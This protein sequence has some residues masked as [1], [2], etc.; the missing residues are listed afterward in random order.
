M[1][2]FVVGSTLC[3]VLQYKA[4]VANALC[5]LC[6]RS[7]TGKCFWAKFVVKVVLGST[8]C[9]SFVVQSRTEE[10]FV[11]ALWY[12]VVLVVEAL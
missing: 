4:V 1:Q 6:G 7:S 10:C 8:L 9:A 5:K 11:Q 3:Q 12:K 2:L